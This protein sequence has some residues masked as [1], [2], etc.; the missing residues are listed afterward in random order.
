MKSILTSSF[1]LWETSGYSQVAYAIEYLKKI[2]AEE[3]ESIVAF[4][5][6]KD[7]EKLKKYLDSP[8]QYFAA[9][10]NLRG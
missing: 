7:L 1:V 3:K 8:D 10:P 5:D 6:S 2:N 9:L 4:S